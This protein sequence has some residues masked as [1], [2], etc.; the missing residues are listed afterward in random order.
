M[1]NCPTYRCPCALPECIEDGKCKY[2]QTDPANG[3]GPKVAHL[4]PATATTAAAITATAVSAKE[5]WKEHWVKPQQKVVAPCHS[6][7]YHLGNCGQARVWVGREAA[8][9][10]RP[11]TGAREDFSLIV[12]LIEYGSTW[13]SSAKGDDFLVSGNAGARELLPADLF[14][15][16]KP[17]PFLHVSWP[18]YGAVS[19][20]RDWWAT[21]VQALSK[22]DG[23]VVLYCMGGHGRTGTAAS[24]LAVLCGWCGP[25]GC[26]VAWVR[27]NYC[28]ETVESDEQLDYIEHITGRPVTSQ[29]SKEWTLPGQGQNRLWPAATT[30]RQANANVTP[31]QPEPDKTPQL[32]K[33]RYKKLSNA[34]RKRGIA[35]PF[36]G[37]LQDRDEVVAD[38]CLFMWNAIDG[39]FEFLEKFDGESG[40]VFTAEHGGEEGCG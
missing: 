20:G 31:A 7:L 37:E 27:D 2:L 14:R 12:S 19:L 15:R 26:P 24:I 11:F 8:V 33:N 40:E 1:M 36:V 32:S 3:N 17:I 21:F 4:Y 38:G 22:I 6:G 25:E 10:R 18:D 9:G 23:D 16:D 39:K 30:P 13:G 5:D 35:A 34:L 28:A 29:A